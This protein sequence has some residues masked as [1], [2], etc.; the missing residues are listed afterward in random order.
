MDSHHCFKHQDNLTAAF[1]GK[2][3]YF[4]EKGYENDKTSSLPTLGCCCG[5][6]AL[7]KPGLATM[8]FAQV[9]G[10]H[11]NDARSDRT[12]GKGANDRTV[13]VTGI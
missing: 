5:S 11:G 13:L 7:Q 6:S 2:T 4:G 1:A 8:D 12:C 3:C 10:A 9:F